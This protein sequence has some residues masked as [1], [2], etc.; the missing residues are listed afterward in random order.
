MRWLESQCS[1]WYGDTAAPVLAS[2]TANYR[3]QLAWPTDIV[4]ELYCDRLGN[5]ALTISHRIVDANDAEA[6]YCDG[7][8]VIVWIDPRTGRS[9]SLP[10]SVRAACTPIRER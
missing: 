9:V 1:D 6:L 3:R 4:V 5:S 7:H 10:A 2:V 8:V